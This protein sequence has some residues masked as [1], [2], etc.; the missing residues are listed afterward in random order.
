AAATALQTVGLPEAKIPMAQ[1]I[2]AICESPKSNSVVTALGKAEAD[3][4]K[5]AHLPVPAHL[6]DTHYQG[7]STLGRGKGYLYPHDY[8][9]HWV[10]QEYM[11]TEL[12]GNTYYTPSAQGHENKIRQQHLQR[13]K[14]IDEKTT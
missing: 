8:P 6:R 14:T 9:G 4:K 2:I 7:A 12:Q 11:P 5:G 1:A 3:A 10:K 13:G